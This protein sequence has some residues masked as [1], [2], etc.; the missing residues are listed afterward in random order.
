MNDKERH[1][2]PGSKFVMVLVFGGILALRYFEIIKLSW[3]IVW[4]LGLFVSGLVAA[5]ISTI[6]HTRR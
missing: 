5:F 2:F 3:L 6:I 4:P 1:D